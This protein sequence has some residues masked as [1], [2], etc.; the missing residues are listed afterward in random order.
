MQFQRNQLS[1][2]LTEEANDIEEKQKKQRRNKV[3]EQRNRK[4]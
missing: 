4:C 2:F 3:K 1:F